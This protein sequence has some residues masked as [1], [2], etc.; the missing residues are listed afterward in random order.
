MK[1]PA[2]EY[3][4][5]ET[6]EEALEVL[7]EHGDEAKLLAGGQSLVPLLNLRVIRPSVLIDLNR[8]DGLARLENGAGPVRIGAMVRQRALELDGDVHDSL[9]LLHEA[10][11]SVAH[12]P[13]RTRGT[14]GGS[15]VHA[16]PAAEIPAVTLALRATMHVAGR[17]GTRAI[18]ASE[19]YLG[20]FMTGLSPTELLVSVEF[21]PQ[22]PGAGWAFV[23]VARVH[24]AFALVGVATLLHAG[25]DGALDDV[26]L[27][28]CGVGGTPVEISGLEDVA[29]GGRPSERLFERVAEHVRATI[30]PFSDNQAGA[31]YR[32]EVA[33]AMSA[34]ALRLAATRAGLEIAAA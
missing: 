22:A 30:E 21:P 33:G 4:V 19:F 1:P 17:G 16:D 6:I 2:F 23:E 20:P 24:G 18:P 10:L 14:L 11:G 13:I 27:A 12:I 29:L 28:L 5:P 31:A 9:P 7:E 8:I 25:R 15:V 34:R 26:R 3:C 32:R